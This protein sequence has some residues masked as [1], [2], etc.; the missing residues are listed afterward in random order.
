[1]KQ[2]IGLAFAL[3]VLFFG[4]FTFASHASRRAQQIAQ[5]G[6]LSFPGPGPRVASGGG[7]SVTF[8]AKTAAVSPATAGNVTSLTVSNMTVGS[9]SNRGLVVHIQ[10]GSIAAYP[11]ATTCTWDS[12]GTNQLMT[13]I[14]GTTTA[15][16]GGI[17]SSSAAFGL[18]APTSGNKSLVCTGWV[19]PSEVHI[20]A[21]S[22]TGVNQ[23]SVAT[24]FPNGTSTVAITA[25]ASPI[26]MT[27]TSATGHMVTAS[28][29]ENCNNI[30]AVTGTTIAIDNSTGP[31]IV[32]ASSYQTGAATVTMQGTFSGT[33]GWI[34]SGTDVSF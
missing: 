18:L 10:F 20:T 7:G 13:I 25:T 32:A 15:L 26:S 8:D 1:M 9:G 24:A 21:V 6:G 12:G 17:T 19:T 33:C 11:V 22:F 23:T 14:P 2:R 30:T 4:T 29:G 31:N 3:L 28:Y 5:V 27:I 34:G 16:N